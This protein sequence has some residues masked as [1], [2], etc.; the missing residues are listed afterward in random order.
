MTFF[1]SKLE[2]LEYIKSYCAKDTIDYYSINL[3]LFEKYLIEKYHSIMMEIEDFR[4]ADFIGY[5][6]YLRQK[7]IKNTS[8]RTYSRAIKVYLRYLYS[9]GYLMEDVTQNVKYPQA[10]A[11]VIMPL[12]SKDVSTMVG[13]MILP[14]NRIIFH[15]MIDCGMRSGE[16]CRLNKEDIDMEK[17]L[18]RINNSKNNKSRILPLPN[19]IKEQIEKYMWHRFDNSPALLVCE[20][21]PERITGHVIKNMF[22]KLK[23]INPHVHAH[24]LRHTFATSYIMGGGNLETLRLLMGHSNYETTRGYIH[25]ANQLEILHYDIYKLDECMFNFLQAYTGNRSSQLKA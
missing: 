18:I 7:D 21:E 5:I 17:R 4:K 19:F 20:N 3:E 12:T 25:L 2:F 8:I 10:D 1:D 13:S 16:V 23:K 11:Q 22:A 9:E 6:S 15:L 14:R 24:L